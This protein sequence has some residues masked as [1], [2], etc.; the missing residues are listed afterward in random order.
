MAKHDSLTN[1]FHLKPKIWK[2]LRNDILTLLDNG[3]DTPPS[4]LDD[5]NGMDTIGK[6]KVAMEITGENGL[7]FS[8]LKLKVRSKKMCMQNQLIVLAALHLTPVTQRNLCNIPKS[9]A[10][11]LRHICNEDETQNYLIPRK[12]NTIT[13]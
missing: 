5:L 8:D 7:K 11:R 4:Y 1:E 10:L 2:V 3:I 9:I 13:C 12:H 6:M